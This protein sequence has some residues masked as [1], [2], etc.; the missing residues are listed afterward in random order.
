MY[1][2]TLVSLVRVYMRGG[3]EKNHSGRVT[4]TINILELERAAKIFTTAIP[5][6]NARERACKNC[7][8]R[9]RVHI[10]MVVAVR[11]TQHNR[12]EISLIDKTI[13][14]E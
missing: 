10:V 3:G 4:R 5:F 1:E 13:Y 9:V 11:T 7:R 2:V 6:N 12:G 8:A 14:G